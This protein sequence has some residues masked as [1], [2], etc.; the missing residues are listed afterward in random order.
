[1]NRTVALRII[2]G[3]ALA[4]ALLAVLAWQLFLPAD[5]NAQRP[6]DEKP[7]T[8]SPASVETATPTPLPTPSDIRTPSPTPS[9]TPSPSQSPTPEATKTPKP[10]ATKTATSHPT[11]TQ[12]TEPAATEP[13]PSPNEG[14][15]TDDV[16][17]DGSSASA[18]PTAD[19]SSGSSTQLPG[20][21]SFTPVDLDEVC[22]RASSFTLTWTASNNAEGY[23]VSLFGASISASHRG[24]GT[25][26]QVAC[27]RV[28]G[29]VQVQGYAYS[30]SKQSEYSYLTLTYSP[31]M[32][33]QD[34]STPLM[35]EEP[36][37][38]P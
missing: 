19:R 25:S 36:T 26:M 18:V 38:T 15:E 8:S 28:A 30:G 14:P 10:S 27:P 12:T 34:S 24:P 32:D 13:E 20:P 6:A 7:E 21:I 3:S 22:N 33:A 1:M 2:A 35:A 31:P 37:A 29:E 4:V 16:P 23:E 11:H 5:S 17:R 9:A